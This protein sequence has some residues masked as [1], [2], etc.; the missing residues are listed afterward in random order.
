VEFVDMRVVLRLLKIV[1]LLLL[2]QVSL[3]SLAGVRA[4]EPEPLRLVDCEIH[5]LD[6]NQS[7]DGF[8]SLLENMDRQQVTA[9][10]VMGVP[11]QKLWQEHAPQRPPA[12][13]SDDGPVYYYGTTDVIVARA[14]LA[15]TPEQRRRFHPFICGFNPTDRNAVNHIRLMLKLYP[16]L[17]SGIGEILTRHD[18]LTHLT[19]G[20]TARADHPALDAVYELAARRRLPVLLHSNITS[21]RESAFIYLGELERALA[22]H[23]K[24]SFVWAHAGTAAN[25]ERR[26]HLKGLCPLVG[27]LLERYPNLKILLSWVLVDHYLL[28]ESGRPAA[29][30]VGLVKRFP[31]RFL[32]GSDV[33]GRFAKLS[34][35]YAGIRAFL[36]GLPSKVA[37]Q[38]AHDN[39]EACFRPPAAVP[40]RAQVKK[41]AKPA[42]PAE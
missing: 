39:A 28:D 6:F 23:P 17:W 42:R 25:I 32:V 27:D 40:D 38:V 26:Q 33:V 30:W 13:E 7:G 37:V 41:R 5:L 3:L 19:L 31:D 15:L 18:A 20:E 8:A 4:A 36:S 29:A 14:L 24:T 21:P 2:C 10:W 1:F 34:G 11:L 35:A 22:A 12:Y 9:A 16:G